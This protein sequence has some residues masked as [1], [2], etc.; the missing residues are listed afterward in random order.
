MQSPV[1]GQR[2]QAVLLLAVAVVY[3]MGTRSLPAGRGEPGPALFPTV[4]GVL[5]V[6]L[7]LRLFW[8]GRGKAQEAGGEKAGK[9]QHRP[10]AY[11]MA[12]VVLAGGFA[13]LFPL[14]G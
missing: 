3:L 13:V 11:P 1:R 12:G 2:I 7:A 9:P 6:L 14:L 10:L 5:L 4:L 8:E